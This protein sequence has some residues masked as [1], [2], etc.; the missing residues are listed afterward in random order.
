MIALLLSMGDSRYALDVADVVEVV[1]HVELRRLPHAP[2]AVAGLFSYRGDVVPVIDL[3]VVTRGTPCRGRLSTRIVLTRYPAQDGNT[4]LL[5]LLAEGVTDTLRVEPDELSP[6]NVRVDGAPYLGDVVAQSG[7]LIQCL[8][9]R[10]LLPP[11][12]QRSLFAPEDA[13]D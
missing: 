8:R 1:P 11:E 6:P 3:C 9:L 7:E 4:H 10:D 2:D 13:R 12:L 5:G